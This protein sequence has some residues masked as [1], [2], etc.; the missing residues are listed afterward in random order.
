MQST[1]WWSVT[2][3]KLPADNIHGVLKGY[4]LT[5][6][7]AYLSDISIGGEKELIIKDFNIY[8]FYY[9]VEELSNY[10]TYH[11][12]VTGFTA[13]GYGPIVEYPA[14]KYSAG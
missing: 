5:Y 13:A 2:W 9:K 4:R 12:S 1:S 14:S 10:E 11:V 6:Y 7:R 8:T 3:G